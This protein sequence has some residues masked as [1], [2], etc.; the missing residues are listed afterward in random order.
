MLGFL[1]NVAGPS[2]CSRSPGLC[3][4]QRPFVV[5]LLSWSLQASSQA[6]DRLFS[7]VALMRAIAGEGYKRPMP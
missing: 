2:S 1:R 5:E 3:L 6:D 7:G 4:Y